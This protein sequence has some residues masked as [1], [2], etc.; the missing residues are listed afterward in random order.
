[1]GAAET[2]AP[3]PARAWKLLGPLALLVPDRSAPA[4]AATFY[5]AGAVRPDLWHVDLD[6][7][8]STGAV[9]SYEWTLDGAP[10]ATSASCDGVFFEVETEG[11]HE[12]TLRVRDSAGGSASHTRGNRKGLL[13][14]K[15]APA[16]AGCALP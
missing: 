12:L 5:F 1:M 7:C 6:A 14:A 8:A 4:A 2:L 15:N 3:R 13:Q 11:A 9:A 16:P 10:L